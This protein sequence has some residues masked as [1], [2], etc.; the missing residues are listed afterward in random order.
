MFLQEPNTTFS[1]SKNELKH[2]KK[3]TPF[4]GSVH[5]ENSMNSLKNSKAIQ[6]DII[7]IF[8]SETFLSS[9][10]DGTDKKLT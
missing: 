2:R 1:S 10:A 5:S 6:L 3:I 7:S 8:T 4:F 9:K